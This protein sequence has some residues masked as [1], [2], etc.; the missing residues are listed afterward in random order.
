MSKVSMGQWEASHHVYNRKEVAPSGYLCFEVVTIC[1]GRLSYSYILKMLSKVALLF[2]GNVMNV[3]H[4]GIDFVSNQSFP[5]RVLAEPADIS[6]V[7][8]R[9]RLPALAH[10]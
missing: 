3:T 1:V 7:S 10:V 9:F 5:P 6:E 2:L 8:P 4:L